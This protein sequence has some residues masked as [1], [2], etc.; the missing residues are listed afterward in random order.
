MK[1]K[2][3]KK[4]K[5]LTIDHNHQNLDRKDFLAFMAGKTIECNPP[6]QLIDNGYLVAVKGK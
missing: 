2:P 3:T 6:K 5:E 4:F 1:Y